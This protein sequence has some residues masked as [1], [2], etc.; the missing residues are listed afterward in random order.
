MSG[1]ARSPSTTAAVS[2]QT[3]A[4]V[5]LGSNSFHMIV[6]RDD[7]GKLHIVDRLKESV[8]LAAGLSRERTLDPK[9]AQRALAC[10][11]RF[12]QR[13]EGLAPGHVRAVGT[14]TL[15]RA[16]DA[17]T[18]LAQASAALGHPVEVIYGAEEARLIYGGVIQDLGNEHPRRLVVDIGGGSTELIVGELAMPELVESVSLGA[19]VQMQ[20][21]FANGK[22]TRK[23]WQA[24]VTDARL[25]LE[26][27]A[28]AYRQAG[29]DLA[30]GASGSIKSILRAAGAQSA[31]ET[32]TPADLKSL[33]RALIKAGRVE[34]LDLP[35]VS[36]ERR[37]IFPGGLAVLTGIFESLGIQAMRVS[38]KALREGV[39]ADLLGRLHDRDARETG[40]L[41]ASERYDV[42]HDQAERVAATA[43]RLLGEYDDENGDERASDM[44]P[45]LL[46]WAALL[47]EIGLAI[48]HKGYHKHGEYILRNADLQ[49]FSRTDQALLATLVRLHRGRFRADLIDAL[50]ENWRALAQRLVIVLRLAVILHR[51]R[52]P[53]LDPPARLQLAGRDIQLLCDARW[54]SDRPLTQADLEREAELLGRAGIRLKTRSED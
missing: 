31:D 52:D 9:S 4:A 40:V 45:R 51:G 10:L 19:V 12:G 26:P 48:S 32:I 42:D 22:I 24:A 8:R 43:I 25:T 54:L 29:W 2:P 21:F 16:R 33:G 17:D 27:Y 1:P 14:N 35:G 36:A 38:D 15:R 34:K 50:P 20:R 47:H 46:R 53:Q 18:F 5:D 3:V 39:V 30:V 23:G 28:R 13:L 6:V 49:G 41:A 37:A 7:G 11:E 44:A